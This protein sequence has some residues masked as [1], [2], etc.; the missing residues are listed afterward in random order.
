MSND[1][2]DW[3][4]NATYLHGIELFNN[5]QFWEA[6]EAWEEIWLVVDGV[7]SDFLQGL[8][9][10]SAALLKYSRAETAP[11][12]RLYKT[13]REK[14]DRCPDQYMGLNVRDFQR[15]MAAAFHPIV[16][17]T[18][19]PLDPNSIPLIRVSIAPQP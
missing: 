13:A 4:T 19:Q 15:A 8:I 14:L 17:G 16:A 3:A 7:Q 10:C 12:L 5:R 2:A 6:H 18:L 1:P 11:A 9:Q